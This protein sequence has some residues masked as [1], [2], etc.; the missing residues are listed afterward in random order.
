MEVTAVA[1]IL[2]AAELPF[3]IPE[4][5]L[6]ENSVVTFCFGFVSSEYADA[7]VIIK[8]FVTTEFAIYV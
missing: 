5:D 2:E 1:K 7:E 4:V 3:E 8:P 6:K